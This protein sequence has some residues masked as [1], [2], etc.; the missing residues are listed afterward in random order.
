M[1]CS[2]LNRFYLTDTALD[3][4]VPNWGSMLKLGSD[5]RCLTVLSDMPWTTRE[6]PSI[7]LQGPSSYFGHSVDM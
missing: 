2:L 4:A 7:E 5:Q 1:T 6:V 3:A